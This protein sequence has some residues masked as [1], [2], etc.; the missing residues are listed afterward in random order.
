[1]V[2]HLYMWSTF[3]ICGPPFT[4]VVHD[5][6]LW[7]AIYICGPPVTFVVYH[8]HLWSK[9]YA[10]IHTCIGNAVGLHAICMQIC[11]AAGLH[12]FCNPADMGSG[13]VHL[14][15]CN[16]NQYQVH[17]YAFLQSILGIEEDLQMHPTIH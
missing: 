4:F 5:L 6:H 12:V 9:G 16:C 14:Y 7:F 17:I 2:H 3:Y 10:Y 15:M 11:R 13:C 8:L 1:M